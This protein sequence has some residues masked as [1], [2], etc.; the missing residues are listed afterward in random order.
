MTKIKLVVFDQDGVLYNVGSKEKPSKGLSTWQQIA[1]AIGALKEDNQLYKRWSRGEFSSYL[2]WMEASVKMHQNQ[3]LTKEKYFSVINNLPY[4][5]YAKETIAELKKRGYLTAIISGGYHAQAIR[6]KKELELDYVFAACEYIFDK[7]KLRDWVLIPCGYYGKVEFLKALIKGLG[8]SLE[9]CA[10]V[11]DGFNDVPL[12]KKVGLSIAF[13][14][15]EELKK[16]AKVI[17]DKRDLREILQY[18]P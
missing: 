10:A 4:T 15:G 13:N 9:Q 2:E 5:P 11:G 8:L 16:V 17:I 6:A 12:A 7:E 14:A 3:G 1:E 18:F